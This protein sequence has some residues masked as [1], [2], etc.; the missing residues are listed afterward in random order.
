MVHDGT[1]V[2]AL[3]RGDRRGGESLVDRYYG[4]VL[5]FFANKAP[6]AADELAR[7]TFLA[8]F[9]GLGDLRDPEGFR[10]FLFAI[11]CDH[12]RAH[13]RR[14][15]E[16]G[17]ALDLGACRAL[18]F[19]ASPGRIEGEGAEHRE[20]LAALRRIPAAAQVLLELA[21]WEA[22][23]AAE[24]AQVLAIPVDA[25]E[26]RLRRAHGLLGR[27]LGGEVEAGDADALADLE[28]RLRCLGDAGVGGWGASG[29][30]SK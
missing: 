19:D 16:G 3:R 24:L 30:A 25:V 15:L 1:L 10:V 23:S 26:A 11:A 13:Y 28:R 5:R 7:R 18:D 2:E 20:L 29:R 17:G 27:E 4:R 12:L 21:Y 8:C 14:G 9:E 6:A 22:L